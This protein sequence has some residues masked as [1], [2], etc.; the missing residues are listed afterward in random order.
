MNELQSIINNTQ[1]DIHHN[2]TLTRDIVGDK[3]FI[4]LF[5]RNKSEGSKHTT[6]SYTYEIKYFLEFIQHFSATLNEVTAKQCLLYREHLKEHPKK[7][8]QA[9]IIRKLNV[10]SSLYKYGMDIGYFRFNPMKAVKKPKAIITS[11]DRYLTPEETTK[12]LNVLRKKPINYLMG[13]ILIT[14]GLRS[15]EL[16]NIKWKDFYEDGKGNIGLRVLGKGTKTR[17]VKIRRDVWSYII[18]YRI[19]KNQSIQFNPNDGAYLFTTRNEKQL[20]PRSIRETIKRAGRKAGLNKDISTH[21]L[22]HTSASLSIN[23][24]CD[25]KTVMETYGWSQMKTAQRYI[26]SINQLEKT[27]TDFISI[28]I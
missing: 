17:V 21:W 6:R 10:I 27:A 8:A 22:R 23:G 25:I 28:N 1:L 19:S 5:L 9:T 18:Q 4:M 2:S 3:D 24:G 20:I 7:Y 26:H 16:S 15:S 11:Q 13:I 12:L 14:T